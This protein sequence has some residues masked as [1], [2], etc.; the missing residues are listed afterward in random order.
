M[1]VTGSLL[2]VD[3]V[4]GAIGPVF[5]GEVT[6]AG[7][8]VKGLVNTRSCPGRCSTVVAAQVGGDL[9]G[10]PLILTRCRLHGTE[11]GAD[12]RCCPPTR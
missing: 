6:M 11:G 1:D 12:G 9:M 8:Q 3:A 7:I 5:H 10:L 2:K 4:T